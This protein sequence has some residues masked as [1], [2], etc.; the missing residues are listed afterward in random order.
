LRAITLSS[1]RIV[2]YTA[3]TRESWVVCEQLVEVNDDC[4]F[5]AAGAYE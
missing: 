3:A 2:S 1:K 4:S 5:Q